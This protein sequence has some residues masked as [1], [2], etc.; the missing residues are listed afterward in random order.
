MAC[1]IDRGPNAKL[2]AAGID[3]GTPEPAA[4][5]RFAVR[6]LW[7]AFFAAGCSSALAPGSETDA[8]DGDASTSEAVDE[9]SEQDDAGETLDAADETPEADE[10][11]DTPHDASDAD[12]A[13]DV[14][15]ETTDAGETIDAS[16]DTFDADSDAAA[17]LDVHSRC[18]TVADCCPGLACQIE[19]PLSPDY[20]VCCRFAP[21]RDPPVPCTRDDDCCGFMICEYGFCQCQLD[22]NVCV[23]SEECCFGECR[24]VVCLR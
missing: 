20:R 17:C 11:F 15:D 19:S 2:A 8:D 16:T 9:A 10:T 14:V 22:G 7:V 21:V 3:D 1:A 6:A 5:R 4:A 23:S 18:T 13:T 12:E 24:G